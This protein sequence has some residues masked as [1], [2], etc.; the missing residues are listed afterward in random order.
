MENKSRIEDI[1]SDDQDRTNHYLKL[2]MATGSK[3]K[4]SV[5][6]TAP[7]TPMTRNSNTTPTSTF[8]KDGPFRQ[9]ANTNKS[10][11]KTKNLP[12]LKNTL[13]YDLI[14]KLKKEKL[15]METSGLKM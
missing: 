9:A 1:A 15:R 5:K 7:S 12:V 3:T 10:S 14:E 4:L 11:S 2:N 6:K 8:L 13:N